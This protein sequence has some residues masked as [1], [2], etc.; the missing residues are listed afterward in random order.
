MAHWWILKPGK[1]LAISLMVRTIRSRTSRATW[2]PAEGRDN[3]LEQ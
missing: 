3:F 2:N 1:A